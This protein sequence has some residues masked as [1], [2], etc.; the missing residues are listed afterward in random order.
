MGI[1]NKK[2]VSFLSQLSFWSDLEKGKFSAFAFNNNQTFIFSEF[3]LKMVI[4]VYKFY[5]TK[6]QAIICSIFEI[7][8]QVIGLIT[9]WFDMSFSHYLQVKFQ[10]IKNT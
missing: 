5:L 1:R 2:S 3:T 6:L 9:Q 10:V 8:F 7:V 4:F